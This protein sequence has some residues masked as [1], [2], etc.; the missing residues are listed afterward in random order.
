MIELTEEEKQRIKNE[1]GTIRY[2]PSRDL[3]RNDQQRPNEYKNKS[4]KL[5]LFIT[6]F[7]V[8][9]TLVYL[10]EFIW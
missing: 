7:F 5:L 8:G 1:W 3:I 9:A 4:R 2:D 10:L 6:G